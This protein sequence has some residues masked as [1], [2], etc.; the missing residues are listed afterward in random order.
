MPLFDMTPA[1]IASIKDRGV[2]RLLAKKTDGM[3]Q[4]AIEAVVA[5]KIAMQ[6]TTTVHLIEAINQS[7]A[8][9]QKA[10]RSDKPVKK[11]TKLLEEK[12]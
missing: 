1:E 7:L 12:K 6:S 4:T 3:V 10:A 9:R 5:D 8:L 2:L 11:T